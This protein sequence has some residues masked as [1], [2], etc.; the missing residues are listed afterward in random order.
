MFVIAV[1]GSMLTGCKED[2][3]VLS[4]PEVSSESTALKEEDEPETSEQAAG[5]A[6]ES[7]D[8]AWEEVWPGEPMEINLNAKIEILGPFIPDGNMIYQ[9]SR[10]HGELRDQKYCYYLRGFFEKSNTPYSE[11][12]FPAALE[13]VS[14]DIWEHG[15]V[16]WNSKLES[17]NGAFLDRNTLE[18]IVEKKETVE[19]N[20]NTFFRE[21][22]LASSEY[23]GAP[24]SSRF[25]AYYYQTEDGQGVCVFGDS[26]ESQD[27]FYEVKE[28][29]E[30][31][32]STY[33]IRE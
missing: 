8:T 14:D 10:Y 31:I 33:R 11:M 1:C 2:T 27:K 28:V 23:M 26:S 32:M 9:A 29:A 25:V 22:V 18:I 20:G 13:D 16:F 17:Q 12:V 15:M 21:E 3:P 19:L 7:A 30:A 24:K 5:E 6:D 4:E